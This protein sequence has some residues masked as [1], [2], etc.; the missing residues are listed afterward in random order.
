M[1]EP[2]NLVEMQSAILLHELLMQEIPLQ[3]SQ[4]PL[5]SDQMITLDKYGIEISSEMRS[6]EKKLPIEW[7][8][9]LEVLRDAEK[10]LNYSKVLQ[11]K[12]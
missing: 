10:M 8:N 1:K 11:I 2:Q 6:M 5:I 4:F 9:Y 7:A 3:E 12:L